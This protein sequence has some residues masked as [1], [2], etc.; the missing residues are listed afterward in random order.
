[1]RGS[2]RCFAQSNR[3]KSERLNNNEC[4]AISISMLSE[5]SIIHWEE[6]FHSSLVDLKLQDWKVKTNSEIMEEHCSACGALVCTSSASREPFAISLERTVTSAW[7]GTSVSKGMAISPPQLGVTL[8]IALGINNRAGSHRA[9]QGIWYFTMW[10]T[11]TSVGSPAVH[12]PLDLLV[13]GKERTGVS[14]SWALLPGY[15]A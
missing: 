2:N 5:K 6:S 3:S 14:C 13:E 4:C 9:F 1:M 8:L 7:G 12:W 10:R 11:V 15:W